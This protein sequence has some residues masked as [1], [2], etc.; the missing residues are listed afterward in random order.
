MQ[1]RGNYTTINKVGLPAFLFKKNKCSLNFC[2]VSY[3]CF[4]CVCEIA[5]LLGFCLYCCSEEECAQKPCKAQI[6]ISGKVEL[7]DCT[8]S[9]FNCY[10][11]Q[12][13]CEDTIRVERL[14]TAEQEVRLDTANYMI[15]GVCLT[16]SFCSQTLVDVSLCFVYL[17]WEHKW[18]IHQ[19]WRW[20]KIRWMF[21]FQTS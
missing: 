9:P 12:Y 14:W 13:R 21:L 18:L 16:F 1:F 15:N 20:R 4:S 3:T 2:I 8:L 19:L 17:K 10:V 5:M 7:P 11:T 6:A